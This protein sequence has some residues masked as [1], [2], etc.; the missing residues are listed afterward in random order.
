MRGHP[1][2]NLTLRYLG[3]AVSA[4]GDD[5]RKKL[6]QNEAKGGWENI[7]TGKLLELLVGELQELIEALNEG[8]PDEVR[9]ECADVGNFAMMIHDNAGRNR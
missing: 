8:T 1:T 9:D 7:P 3:P 2:E 5:M 6:R 4:F